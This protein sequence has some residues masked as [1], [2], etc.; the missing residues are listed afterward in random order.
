MVSIRPIITRARAHRPKSSLIR[1][2]ADAS[3]MDHLHGKKKGAGWPLFLLAGF[4]L[5]QSAPDSYR[6][7]CRQKPWRR[8]GKDWAPW[9]LSSRKDL[10]AEE[11]NGHGLM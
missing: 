3:V 4:A 7:T 2:Q 1:H 11:K 6:R 9:R 8:C 5:A 10:G